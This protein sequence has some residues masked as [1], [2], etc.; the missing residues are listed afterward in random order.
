LQKS[1]QKT[2][3]HIDARGEMKRI[4]L[5]CDW[6][7]LASKVKAMRK[8]GQWESR[9][10]E[11]PFYTLGKSAYLDG[12]SKIYYQQ[13][14]YLNA[15]LF[16]SFYPLYKEVTKK[17]S[18][19]FGEWVVFNPKLALPGFHI[20]PADKKL[21]S[22]AGNWHL[23]SPHE[24]LGVGEKDAYAFTLALELPTGGGGM[25]VKIGGDSDEYVEYKVGELLLHDGMTPH[26]I[27]PYRKYI[28]GEHRITMQG[29]IVRN[30]RELIT[31]W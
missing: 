13:S 14:E 20:F 22:V 7:S 3:I 11:F 19:F 6:V 1:V 29:H 30:G 18:A 26:R 5:D 8:I 31:F 16:R 28:E 4:E 27:S 17:L 21:L 9:S 15:L 23:D 12:N 25:D 24:T 2:K 10:N